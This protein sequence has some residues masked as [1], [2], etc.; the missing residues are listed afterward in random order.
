MNVRITN[1]SCVPDRSSVPAGPVTFHVTNEGG[2]RVSEIELTQNGRI[3]GEKENLVPGLSGE[4][5]VSLEAG[6]YEIECPGADLP[7][8]PFTVTATVSPSA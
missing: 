1:V 7:S 3:L 4:F 6:D 5:S 2:D 8:S